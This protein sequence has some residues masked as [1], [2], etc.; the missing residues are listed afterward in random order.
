MTILRVPGRW[1]KTIA[2][3]L[4]VLSVGVGTI[5]TPAGAASPAS[6]TIRFYNSSGVSDADMQSARDA[7]ESILRDTRLNVI[8]RHCGRSVAPGEAVDP[9]AEPLKPSEVVVRIINAPAFSSTLHPEAYGLAYVVPETNRGW[10]ATV[11]SD[12]IGRAAA[13][14]HVEPGTLLGLVAAHEIGHLLLGSNYHGE[15]GVMRPDLSDASLTRRDE[16]WRFSLREAEQLNRALESIA[17]GA[18]A[19][20]PPINF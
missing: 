18:A 15:G 4:L 2:A 1:M 12:R 10:L 16:D 7:A 17:G 20:A 14:L 3:G 19:P 9:C 13:R 8:F 5:S 6:L 11:F